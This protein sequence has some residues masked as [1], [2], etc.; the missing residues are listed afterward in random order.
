M[1]VKVD[2]KS[3]GKLN[4][5]SSNKSL[6]EFNETFVDSV[7]ISQKNSK[8]ISKD[9]TILE[10]TQT[11]AQKTEEEPIISKVKNGKSPESERTDP[12]KGINPFNNNTQTKLKS[13][14]QQNVDSTMIKQNK[15]IINEIKSLEG[16]ILDT[17][18]EIKIDENST[19][20]AVIQTSVHKIKIDDSFQ[21]LM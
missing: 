17:Q 7:I 14:E 15:N 19:K 13:D 10:E 4:N 20:D 1:G 18:D 6:F 21:E 5:K 11:K 3:S 2:L 12:N 16:L 8:E 9:K